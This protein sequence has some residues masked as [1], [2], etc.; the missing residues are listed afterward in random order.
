MHSDEEVRE[1]GREL[2]LP[3]LPNDMGPKA[4]W[5]LVFDAD[6]PLYDDC[7]HGCGSEGSICHV[8]TV[9]DLHDDIKP[10]D[11]FDGRWD[12]RPDRHAE[13]TRMFNFQL[14]EHVQD[15]GW[16]SFVDECVE[17][18][19]CHPAMFPSLWPILQ[20]K[21]LEAIMQA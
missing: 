4:L 19:A 15:R 13:V 20:E 12:E 10:T 8:I 18:F 1:Q 7:Y 21:N 2:R 3:K 16:D 17:L 6:L 9:L 14:V 11:F 5:T